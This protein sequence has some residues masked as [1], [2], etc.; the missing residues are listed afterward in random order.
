MSNFCQ[1][2]FVNDYFIEFDD[3]DYPK[4]DHIKSIQYNYVTNPNCYN[5]IRICYD[6]LLNNV[7]KCDTEL[8]YKVLQELMYVISIKKIQS[9]W[10]NIIYNINNKMGKKFIYNHISSHSKLYFNI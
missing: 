10:I 7:Y 9:W 6:C 4:P 2:C 1:L 8:K 5:P 3:R